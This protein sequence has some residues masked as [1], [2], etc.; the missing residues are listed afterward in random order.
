MQDLVPLTGIACSLH[1][2]AKNHTPRKNATEKGQDFKSLYSTLPN[3][4]KCM[5]YKRQL[6]IISVTSRS[7]LE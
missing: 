3:R 7:S 5:E 2:T 1:A 6:C 4:T